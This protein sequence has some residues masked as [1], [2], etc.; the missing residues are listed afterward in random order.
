M[1]WA[2]RTTLRPIFKRRTFLVR[3]FLV[4]LTLL[5]YETRNETSLSLSE[6]R[7]RRASCMELICYEPKI[8]SGPS[9]PSIGWFHLDT[10]IVS[11]NRKQS[12]VRQTASPGTTGGGF[13]RWS[14]PWRTGRSRRR[15]GEGLATGAC[16]SGIL[17]GQKV[18]MI[19]SCWSG[20]DLQGNAEVEGLA[21]NWSL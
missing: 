20:W 12:R 5:P 8:W 4:S 18:Q 2:V 10:W 11:F 13:P 17:P 16:W 14:R 15:A 9:S 7:A 21:S 1:W 6:Y 19:S 3:A